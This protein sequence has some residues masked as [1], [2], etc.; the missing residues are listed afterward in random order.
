MCIRDSSNTS[1][2]ADDGV[3]YKEIFLEKNQFKFTTQ[4][5][6]EGIIN[7]TVEPILASGYTKNFYLDQFA[8][9]IVSDLNAKWTQQTT[10]TNQST[11]RFLDSTDSPYMTGSFT[12]NSLRFIEPGAMCRFTAP[13]GFHFMKDGTLMSGSADHLGSSNY[14][15]A[16]VVS[17]DGNG[18][19][20]NAVNAKG[21][22]IFNDNVP[23]NAI[24]DRIVPNFSRILVDSVKV[25]MI[26]QA[27]AY[28]DFGLRYDL[29][30]RQWKIVTSEN[31]NTT[32][33]F[34]TGKTG[35]TTGQNLDSSWLLYFKT[36]GETYTITYRN[37]RY[38]IESSDEI[39]FYFDGIDKV[40]N[41][42]TG[43]IVRDKI[44]ILNLSLIHI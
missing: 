44:D 5:D 20:V 22:I 34:S 32:L 25:Q 4:S 43:K 38:V 31:I 1:L 6:I 26:D 27:F 17:V 12:A 21:P 33:G 9:T 18:T 8:K 40:Y 24:L 13:T 15:W 14:K 30:D 29:S 36:D 39:R 35:D 10:S 42:A 41:P 11:G 3:L 16:K 2:F 23:T 28:K 19:V 7:N 37:L